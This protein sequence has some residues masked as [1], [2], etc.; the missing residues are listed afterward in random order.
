[1]EDL[2]LLVFNR[3]SSRSHISR[4]APLDLPYSKEGND[5]EVVS[6][7]IRHIPTSQH[8]SLLRRRSSDS[9]PSPEWRQRDASLWLL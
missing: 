1:M 5:A 3:H 8:P 4:I 9:A 2:S 6:S 7:G